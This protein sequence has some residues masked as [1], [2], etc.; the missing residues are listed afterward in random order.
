MALRHVHGPSARCNS[1]GRGN[2]VVASAPL[3][4]A[5]GHTTDPSDSELPRSRSC[6]LLRGEVYAVPIPG[7]RHRFVGS[8]QAPSARSGHLSCAPSPSSTSSVAP[9][10]AFI[11]PGRS[12]SRQHRLPDEQPTLEHL[13]HVQAE[14]ALGDESGPFR[15]VERLRLR[16]N[17]TTPRATAHGW[18]EPAIAQYNSRQPTSFIQSTTNGNR[19]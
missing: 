9:T 14:L 4:R 13:H 2:G 6:G 15:R 10:P 16:R 8:P 18:K 17:A 11:R 5:T 1:P 3:P 7:H 19:Y 12:H